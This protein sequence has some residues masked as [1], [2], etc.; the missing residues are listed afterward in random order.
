MDDIGI[1]LSPLAKR[2]TADAINAN[3]A[4][5]STEF[6]NMAIIAWAGLHMAST[7]DRRIEER[8]TQAKRQAYTH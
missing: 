2:L 8:L 5:D 3:V 4:N 6:V 1:E 7:V